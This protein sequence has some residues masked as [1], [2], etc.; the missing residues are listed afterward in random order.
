[1]QSV[2]K[3]PTKTDLKNSLPSNAKTKDVVLEEVSWL[4][5]EV[6]ISMGLSQQYPLKGQQN[7][8]GVTIQKLCVWYV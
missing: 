8:N 2:I 5:S 3:L 7:L 6:T 4:E 1:M